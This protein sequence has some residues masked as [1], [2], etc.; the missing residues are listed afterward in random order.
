MPVYK[1]SEETTTDDQG[2]SPPSDVRAAATPTGPSETPPDVAPAPPPT[3]TAP[4]PAAETTVSTIVDN[5]RADA[6]EAAPEPM[7]GPPPAAEGG[8]RIPPPDAPGGT[9]D[10]GATAPPPMPTCDPGEVPSIEQIHD[11]LAV[12]ARDYPAVEIRIINPLNSEKHTGKEKYTHGVRFADLRRAAEYAH[13]WSGEA[14]GVYFT[15]NPLNG[16]EVKGK[17]AGDEDVSRR[18]WLFIDADPERGEHKKESATD[19]EKAIAWEALCKVRDWL[20]AWLARAGRLR[21][22][23]RLASALPARPAQRR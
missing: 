6:P 16:L 10:H 19:E 17:T 18:M 8:G 12:F 5:G 23:Q 9:P 15:I 20:R 21:L 4:P 22:G 13:R 3:P 2:F 11:W 1:I 7:A 14:M